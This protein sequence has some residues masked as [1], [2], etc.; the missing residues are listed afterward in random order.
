MNRLLKGRGKI[1]AALFMLSGA[2]SL[3][4]WACQV[5]SGTIDMPGVN[6]R[7]SN[8]QQGVTLYRGSHHINYTC[9]APGANDSLQTNLAF[10]QAFYTNIMNSDF[11]RSGLGV[12]IIIQEKDSPEVTIT[13]AELK[14]HRA[15]DL[16]QFGK[17]RKGD[18]GV[19][20]FEPVYLSA[21]IT[22]EL[23]IDNKFNN[24][25][26][27]MVNGMDALTVYNSSRPGITESGP[28]GNAKT[29]T[30]SVRILSN[31]LGKVIVTPLL[32]NLG[33]FYTSFN[34]TKRS[35]PFTVTAQQ[36]EGVVAPFLMPLK[37]KFIPQD[38]LELTDNDTAMKLKNTGNASDN[39]LQLSIEDT[40]TGGKISFNKDEGMG[41]ISLGGSAAS[42]SVAKTYVAVL[43]EV[44]GADVTTGRFEARSTVIVTYE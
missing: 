27:F 38:G 17:N 42:G 14:S 39:G 43:S 36:Q 44:P 5:T 21:D 10:T 40:A 41:D 1:L 24:T 13:W 22:L 12:N 29:G 7:L 30:F 16:F 31:S 8:I 32:V 2:V 35:A 28:K 34:G 11:G 15:G 6:I 33:N 37:I 25:Q 23:F 9:Y 4:A 20:P 18:T 26:S 19:V 3:P